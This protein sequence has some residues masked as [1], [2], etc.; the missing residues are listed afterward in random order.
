MNT[1]NE[2]AGRCPNLLTLSRDT[3]APWLLGLFLVL[4]PIYRLPGVDEDVLRPL[5]W[6]I[7]LMAAGL[8]LGTELLKGRLPHPAGMLGPLGFAGVLFLSVP[9]FIQAS[10]PFYVIE[11]VIQVG[12]CGTFFWCFF[13]I[14]RSG[15]DVGAI[16]RR[17]FVILAALS[18][19]A[20]VGTLSRV[21]DWT[22]LCTWD[23]VDA[24]GF[25]SAY[26]TA[27]SNGLALFLPVAALFSFS[28]KGRWPSAWEAV[29]MVGAVVLM[30]SQFV[31]GGRGG[32]L[33]SIACI[34]AFAIRPSTRRLAAVAAL[35]GLSLAGKVYLDQSCFEHLRLDH[36]VLPDVIEGAVNPDA[37]AK[38]ILDYISTRRISGYMRGLAEIMERPL[39]GHGLRQV[40][41]DTPWGEQTEIHNL[42]LK[43]AVYTGISAPLCF[44]IMVVLV[45]RR[46]WRIFRDEAGTGASRD[47]SFALGLILVL[48]LA[49]SMLEINIPIGAFQISSIWWAAAGSLA[50]G[51]LA[52]F[53]L[54]PREA[55]SARSEG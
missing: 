27:W 43:W 25:G 51:G 15:G 3:I 54:R 28:S 6:S 36:L 18:G 9:G 17:A 10:E 7:F 2:Q 44:F 37:A 19:M 16:F 21:P 34:A 47:Q 32:L 5:E 53:P 40:M 30:G 52:A 22:S 1:E 20:L 38:T 39:L 45:L 31:S 50:G 12:L 26:T 55:S 11:F 4:G 33:V 8:V 48:G 13:C 29:G 46:G 23:P 35:A 41:L 14:A 24:I 49:I 42:W